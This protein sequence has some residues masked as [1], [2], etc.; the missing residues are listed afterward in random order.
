MTSLICYIV[1]WLAFSHRDRGFEPR[2]KQT[3]DYK[4]GIGFF[5]AKH[6]SIRSQSKDCFFSELALQKST[7][8]CEFITKRTS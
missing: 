4:I 7:S 5:S 8:A 3:K 1:Q 2:S 6:T